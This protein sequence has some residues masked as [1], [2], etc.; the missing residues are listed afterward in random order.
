M[1][2][3]RTAELDLSNKAGKF[4]RKWEPQTACLL[5]TFPFQPIH[6][7]PPTLVAETFDGSCPEFMSASYVLNK[8]RMFSSP[9]IS[10]SSSSMLISEDLSCKHFIILYNLICMVSISMLDPKMFSSD[11]L[12]KTGSIVTYSGTQPSD[13]ALVLK[14]FKMIL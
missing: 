11:M 4:N 7:L 10:P 6:S 1:V 2:I 9:A 8:L 5:L 3:I 13:S 12:P 14:I